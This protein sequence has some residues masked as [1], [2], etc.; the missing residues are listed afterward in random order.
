VQGPVE[1]VHGVRAEGVADL[2]PVEGDAH[3]GQ[4]PGGAVGVVLDGAVVGD[5]REVE[6][7]DGAP[8]A[9]VEGV[10]GLGAHARQPRGARR[11]GPAGVVAM[12]VTGHGAGEIGTFVPNRMVRM[13]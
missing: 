5:V 10:V 13:Y 2:G 8:A 6:A 7:L 1:L 3:R 12:H 9:R 4:V 11:G